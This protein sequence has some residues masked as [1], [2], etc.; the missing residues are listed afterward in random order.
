MPSFFCGRGQSLQTLCR[1]SEIRQ[2]VNCHQGSG[3]VCKGRHQFACLN[4][5][6]KDAFCY[7]ASEVLTNPFTKKKTFLKYRG[8][9]GFEIICEIKD[10]S[11]VESPP[12]SFHARLGLSPAAL[13]GSRF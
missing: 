13:S 10:L 9:W 2:P 1:A 5:N 3:S 8:F 12:K 4:F 7:F 11:L 6:I